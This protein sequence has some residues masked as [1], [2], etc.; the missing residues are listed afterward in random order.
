VADL[1]KKSAFNAAAFLHF[2]AT[3][4][5]VVFCVAIESAIPVGASV[6]LPTT[7]VETKTQQ[8]VQ[9]KSVKKCLMIPLVAP[10]ISREN[11]G[12]E[13]RRNLSVE[14]K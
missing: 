12:L 10:L 1:P 8:A 4:P 2:G 3:L 9:P 14:S 5:I 13:C 7:E 11:I 6:L